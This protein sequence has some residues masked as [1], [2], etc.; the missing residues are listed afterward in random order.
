[1]FMLL[2]LISIQ[3]TSSRKLAG[4]LARVSANA[5]GPSETPPPLHPRLLKAALKM[6]GGKTY[7]EIVTL[8]SMR[9][10]E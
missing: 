2:T 9:L 6:V 8:T 4:H 5:R 7:I 10:P 3:K 1:M